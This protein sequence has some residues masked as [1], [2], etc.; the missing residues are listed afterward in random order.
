MADLT[1]FVTGATGSIGSEAVRLLAASNLVGQVRAGTRSP[2][3]SV[4][5]HFAGISDK[6]VPCQIEPGDPSAEAAQQ[7]QAALEGCGALIVVAP[8]IEGMQQWH[9]RLARAAAAAGIPF[10]VK[11]S[12]TGARS[13]ESEPPP[14]VMPLMHWQGEQALRDEGLD[15]V[16]IRPTIFMQ[17]FLTVPA[18]YQSGEDRFYLPSGEGKIAFL[19][20]RDIARLAVELVLLPADQQAPFIGQGFELTGPQA[21]TGDQIA[22]VLSDA[23]G[24]Q[25]VRVDGE[26]AFSEHAATLGM[27]DMVKS[28]YVEASQGWFGTVT[29]DIFEEVTGDPTRPY[30][31]FFSDNREFFTEH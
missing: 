1:V 11:V 25:I 10:V 8:L 6:I 4:A 7:L 9:Q 27:P 13:P 20:N 19:D 12:V 21:L 22:E 3:A 26:E 23:V 18:L 14:G 24:R 31:D 29:Y 15:V 2:A 17:H 5:E 16:A 30:A 28:V